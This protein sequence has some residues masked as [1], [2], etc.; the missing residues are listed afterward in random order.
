MYMWLHDLFTLLML[1]MKIPRI[2]W[3][4]ELCL[5]GCEQNV[6]WKESVSAEQR[7]TD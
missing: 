2:R 7:L 4:E 1:R 3:G 5:S 6:F